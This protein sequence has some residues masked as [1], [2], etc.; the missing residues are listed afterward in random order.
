MTERLH[1]HFSQQYKGFPGGTSGKE[2]ACQCRRCKRHRFDPW[3]GKIP[4]RRKWQPTPVFLI[5]ESHG[6]GTWQATVHRITP[7][8]APLR[9]LSMKSCRSATMLSINYWSYIKM[10]VIYWLESFYI[11]IYLTVDLHLGH[12]ESGTT[13]WL[14]NWPFNNTGS[15]TC[16][17]YSI[18]RFY[19]T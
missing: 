17:S 9:W 13:V 5:G 15:V 14:N 16:R 8:Q 18:K 19:S 6:R 3:V 4:W 10:L 1:F 2:P 12:E 11:Y 7:S